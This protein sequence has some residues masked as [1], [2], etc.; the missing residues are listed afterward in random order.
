MPG[1]RVKYIDGKIQYG[2]GRAAQVLGQTHDV[3]RLTE[4]TNDSVLGEKPTLVDFP[5]RIRRT[6][7][8]MVLEDTIF[9]LIAYVALCDNTKLVLGDTLKETGYKSQSAN[10]YTYAQQRPTRETVF[11]RTETNSFLSR[12]MP[13]AGQAAQLPASGP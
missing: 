5:A 13:T 8:K 2:R 3:Y 10:I 9:D 7:S 1:T 6:T 11:M 12:P 4:Q